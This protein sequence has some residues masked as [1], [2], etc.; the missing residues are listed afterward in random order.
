M[1]GRRCAM[2]IAGAITVTG[3]YVE[4]PAR[5]DGP[6]G[7]TRQP[8][9]AGSWY[10]GGAKEPDVLK[11]LALG[12]KLGRP[13]TASL[14]VKGYLSHR[15]TPSAALLLA[16][17]ENA[18]WVGD[19]RA[20]AARYKS[21]LR[22]NGSG[23]LAGDTAGVLYSIL[24]D[25]LGDSDDAY[26]FM[27]QYGANLRTTPPARRFDG[28]YVRQAR[29]R[30]DHA[31]MARMLALIFAQKMPIEQ[32]RLFFWEHLDWLL[33]EI[34]RAAPDQYAALPHARKLAGLIRNSKRRTILA[35]LYVA[36]LAF[37]AGS[38]GKDAAALT[39]DFAQ[40]TKAAQAYFNAFPSAQTLQDIV[41]TFAGGAGVFSEST[42]AVQREAK[43]ALFVG[44]FGRLGDADRRKVLS[45]QD[46]SRGYIARLL[47]SLG[48]R[49][50]LAFS[51]RSVCDLLRRHQGIDAVI[52][53][54]LVQRLD[55]LGGE[56]QPLIGPTE[57][58]AVPAELPHPQLGL[59][60]DLV[61]LGHSVEPRLGDV[62]GVAA[63][64][65]PPPDA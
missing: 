26:R 56:G 57:V 48:R 37:K 33:A 35:N 19:Y 53:D 1:K 40:V 18:L 8:A 61:D 47:A 59:G 46:R 55:V 65:G 42:W 49:V 23:A 22:A 41:Y 62:C 38:A 24:I 12:K 6:S 31:N 50:V 51:P 52:A 39:K 3:M 63:G 4:P 60:D 64:I 21:F 17:A 54:R 10:P 44:A 58:P 30:A 20:A 29:S 36:N 27:T 34:S 11:L 28:W 43:G 15:A 32:E 14:A 45:W 25:L 13:Y 9:C 2:L 7:D 16:A 5:A